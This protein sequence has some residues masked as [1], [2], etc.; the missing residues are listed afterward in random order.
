MS[1]FINK[2]DL[3]KNELNELSKKSIVFSNKELQKELI[4]KFRILNGAKS[5]SSG[6]FQSYLKNTLDILVALFLSLEKY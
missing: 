6:I 4:N 2:A 3:N 1:N 5:F